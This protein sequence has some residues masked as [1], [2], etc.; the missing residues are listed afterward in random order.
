MAR[1]LASEQE[2]GR[3]RIRPVLMALA[4]EGLPIRE[5]DRIASTFQTKVG[6][7]YAATECPFLSYG[8]EQKWLHVN[9]DW[10]IL[11]PVDASHRPVRPGI[12]SHTVLITNLANRVQPILRYDLGDSV[13]E[14]PDPC[15]CGNP[16]PAIRVQGRSAD[17][18]TFRTGQGE[19]VAIAPLAFEIDHI[20]GLQLF[21]IVQTSPTNLC[22][23]L[24]PTAG[25][26]ADRIWL[27]A[28]GEIVRLLSEHR[29]GH[30]TVER[31]AEPP[32]QGTGGK[33]RTVVPFSPAPAR[34]REEHQT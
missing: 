19:L 18:H 11:E 28:Q 34:D 9:A 33:F 22:L 20:P 17:V 23:R 5:Y 8:C 16:L 7:S 13:I 6:N 31:A 4:A 15:P 12:Q 21:Q 30:V 10:A 14:R 29:L 2:S 27:E 25:A 26:V 32:Q 3:L 24:L 1:L